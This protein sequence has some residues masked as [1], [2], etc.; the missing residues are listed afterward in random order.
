MRFYT[1]NSILFRIIFYILSKVKI[2]HL[3]QGGVARERTSFVETLEKGET[4]D[5]GIVG[6]NPTLGTTLFRKNC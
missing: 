5:L 1:L 6:S 2:T 4:E 3:S